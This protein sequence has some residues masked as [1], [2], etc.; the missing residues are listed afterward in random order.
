MPGPTQYKKAP[1]RISGNV[2]T[3]RRGL[4]FDAPDQLNA[5]EPITA[6][7]P[8]S[9]S[10]VNF[11]QVKDQ[12]AAMADRGSNTVRQS[13][14]NGGGGGGGTP[15]ISEKLTGFAGRHFTNADLPTVWENPWLIINA[16]LDERGQGGNIKLKEMMR[17]YGEL[18]LPIFTMLNGLT[19]DT[20]GLGS[21]DTI[22]WMANWVNNMSKLGG[23]VP[24]YEGLLNQI[25]Q[26]RGT[27]TVLGEA[28]NSGTGQDQVNTLMTYL[29]A[30]LGTNSL[31][32]IAASAVLSQANREGDKFLAQS[33]R[34][35]NGFKGNL[36][37]WLNGA[38]HSLFGSR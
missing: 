28:L 27:D 16:A 33:V 31:N 18:G 11:A 7:T 5:S 8:P 13:Q 38:P 21:A 15:P 10:R 22:N 20:A 26:A 25:L 32:P 4:G 3:N 34:G 6:F 19:D 23:P 29:R 36:T 14:I 1:K 17:Q 12:Q 24:T 9:V 35:Q 2:A 30:A 37:D